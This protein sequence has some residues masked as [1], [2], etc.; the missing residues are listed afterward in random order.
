MNRIDELLKEMELNSNH[1]KEMNSRNLSNITDVK[2]LQEFVN[3]MIE[4]IDEQ[5]IL[6]LNAMLEDIPRELYDI[7]T[8][9][10]D[11]L[12]TLRDICKGRYDAIMSMS[13]L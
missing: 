5:A 13:N 10:L 9:Q 8:K 7:L 12:K 3:E 11:E 6:I 4:A 2:E 1:V